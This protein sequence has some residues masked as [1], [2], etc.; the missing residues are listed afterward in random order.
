MVETCFPQLYHVK[1][2]VRYLH[3]RSAFVFHLRAVLCSSISRQSSTL[4]RRNLASRSFAISGLYSLLRTPLLLDPPYGLI[5]A[6]HLVLAYTPHLRRWATIAL[7]S[8]NGNE[9]MVVGGSRNQENSRTFTAT[10]AAE[11]TSLRQ[12]EDALR[13]VANYLCCPVEALPTL[14]QMRNS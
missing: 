9:S 8:S 1:T 5:L 10:T 14:A 11:I 3:S 12:C 6:R 2:I 7:A 4:Q 13:Q